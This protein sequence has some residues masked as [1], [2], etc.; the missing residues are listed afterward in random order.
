MGYTLWRNGILLGE[1]AV[2]YPTTSPNFVG[3]MFVPT[4]AFM[5]RTGL[6]QGHFPD[7]VGA[8]FQEPF[9]PA[10]THG[11]PV[12]LLPAHSY[13]VSPERVLEIRDVHNA[14]VPTDCI[15]L[16][17]TADLAPEP[18]SKLFEACEARGVPYSRWMLAVHLAAQSG[19][20]A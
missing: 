16:H 20:A 3:G 5:E 13:V 18:G 9:A 17:E 8:L 11:E 12:P 14:V 6:V 1:I 15:M 4:S 19:N 10:N 7:P 2:E